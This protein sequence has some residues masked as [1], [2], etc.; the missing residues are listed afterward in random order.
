[1]DQDGLGSAGP[2]AEGLLL[3]RRVCTPQ[4][5]DRREDSL[6]DL[7]GPCSDS[8]QFK[9]LHDTLF[10]VAWGHLSSCL[11]GKMIILFSV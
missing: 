8:P 11:Y 5:S 1:M 10:C 4:T 6:W 9:I 3:Q 7:H 2:W